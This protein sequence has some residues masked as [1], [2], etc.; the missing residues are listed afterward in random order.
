MG[1]SFGGGLGQNPGA[2]VCSH[3]GRAWNSRRL[4][5]GRHRTGG[6]YFCDG[7]GRS[8]RFRISRE[9]G[10]SA[11]RQRDSAHGARRPVT[12]EKT[13]KKMRGNQSPRTPLIRNFL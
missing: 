6:E 8:A 3:G 9:A 12:K 7:K 10:Q 1:R 11:L 5:S 4:F 2:G 13:P